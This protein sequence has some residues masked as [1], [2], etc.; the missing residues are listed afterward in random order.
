MK[1]IDFG[2]YDTLEKIGGGILGIV[3]IGATIAEMILGGIDAASIA[4]AIKDIAG[5]L[6][7]VMVLLVAL[8]QLV[9]KKTQDFKGVFD[10]EMDKILLKYNPLIEKD[11]S[12]EGR[13]NIAS[14]IDAIC[15]NNTGKFHTLFDF[16][17]KNEL[18]FVVSKTL[19]MGRTEKDFSEMQKNIVGAITAKIT[20]DYDIVDKRWKSTPTGFK[21]NFVHELNSREEAIQAAEIVD[22]I[23]LLYIAEYKK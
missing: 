9:P 19:F 4:G 1:R 5:T 20:R 18:T 22:T 23:I 10:E 14:R 16:D 6:I 13:Y 17:Y 7:V 3:A 21:L 8:K 12:K 11:E 2:E 15:D